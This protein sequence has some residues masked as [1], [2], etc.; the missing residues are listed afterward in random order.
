MLLKVHQIS[1]IILVLPHMAPTCFLRLKHICRRSR[2]H[3]PTLAALE[4]SLKAGREMNFPGEP[5][6][7]TV[8]GRGADW[9]PWRLPGSGVKLW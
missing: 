1:G 9:W 4:V 3:N 8:T 5:G 6:F 2:L 7:E